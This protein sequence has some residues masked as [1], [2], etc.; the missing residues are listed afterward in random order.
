MLAVRIGGVC[1]PMTAPS[2]NLSFSFSGQLDYIS[3]D[4]CNKAL[5]LSKS[6]TTPVQ[7][8]NSLL[9]PRP[10]VL[11]LTM[12]LAPPVKMEAPQMEGVWIPNMSWGHADRVY[13]SDKL[14][15]RST[16]RSGAYLLQ[17]QTL[18]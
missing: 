1:T 8:P 3:Q 17:K 18:S 2:T 13:L 16:L 10:Q 7:A 9:C 14:H 15:L 5:Q 4:P 12:T 11:S 6:W